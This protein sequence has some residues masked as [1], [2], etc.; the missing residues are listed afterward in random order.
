MCTQDKAEQQLMS[1]FY[2]KCDW[3]RARG[4][5]YNPCFFVHCTLFFTDG[6]SIRPGVD[7]PDM[8]GAFPRPGDVAVYALLLPRAAWPPYYS[9]TLPRGEVWNARRGTAPWTGTT[10]GG[11]YSVPSVATSPCWMTEVWLNCR[12]T[13]LWQILLLNMASL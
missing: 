5:P 10:R 13:S 6:H 9:P 1:Q 4:Y 7:V 8:P 12:K 3:P 11:S 2:N